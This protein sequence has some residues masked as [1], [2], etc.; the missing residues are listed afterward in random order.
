MCK[1]QISKDSERIKH[2]RGNTKKMNPLTKQ[3]ADHAFKSE[4]AQQSE[5]TTQTPEAIRIYTCGEVSGQKTGNQIRKTERLDCTV[6]TLTEMEIMNVGSD[7]I[8]FRY[9]GVDRII[10]DIQ[11][12][13]EWDEVYEGDRVKER[14]ERCYYD[15]KEMSNKELKEYCIDNFTESEIE[16]E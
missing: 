1:A 7:S 8:S 14:Y 9:K 16:I 12:E 15:L 2:H 11:K 10:A 3:G 5:P 4:V 6:S 13:W